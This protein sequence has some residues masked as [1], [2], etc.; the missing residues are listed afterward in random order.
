MVNIIEFPEHPLV[1]RDWD[2]ISRIRGRFEQM[3]AR[4]SP[5]PFFLLTLAREL[6]RR[7]R[8]QVKRVAELLAVNGLGGE[9]GD[10]ARD[11]GW[12]NLDLMYM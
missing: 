2:L 8:G 6:E 1:A 9:R 11:D 4:A 5:E 12:V 10:S 7:A 3:N